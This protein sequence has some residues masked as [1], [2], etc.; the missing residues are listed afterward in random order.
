MLFNDDMVWLP[1]AAIHGAVSGFS[2][3]FLVTQGERVYLPYLK[4]DVPIWA[5]GFC[6]GVLSSFG[7][8]IV[9]NIVKDDV[10]IKNKTQDEV[11][12]FLSAL[13]GGLFFYGSLYLSGPTLPD[14]VGYLKSFAIGAAGE[15]A[16]AFGASLL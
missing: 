1:K 12:M 2:T 14:E 4:V 6:S 16:S 3:S 11:S 5:V 9:H 7:S 8:D 10:H 13:L 15:I